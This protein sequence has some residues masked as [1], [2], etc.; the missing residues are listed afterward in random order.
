MHKSEASAAFSLCLAQDGGYFTVGGH[1]GAYHASNEKIQYTRYSDAFGQYK[2]VLNKIE[3]HFLNLL[4]ILICYLG[5]WKRYKCQ[6][7]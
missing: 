2:I 6:N 7:S 5:R 4:R 1:N 3:V